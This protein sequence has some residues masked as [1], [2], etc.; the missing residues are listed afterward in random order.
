MEASFTTAYDQFYLASNRSYVSYD[1]YLKT[2]PYNF[3]WPDRPDFVEKFPYQDGLLVNYW[4][5]SYSDNNTSA[6]P[7]SGVVLPID[8]HPRAHYNL[9]GA[10]WRGRIQNYDAPFGLQK[11]DSF[12]LHVNGK[13]SYVRGQAANAVFDDSDP[14][15]Y[16][17]PFAEAGLPRVGVKVA[18]V[19]VQDRGAQAE[20]RQH[21]DPDP[22]VTVRQHHH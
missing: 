1:K 12:T 11:A 13:A 18:G 21:D 3:G 4:D 6:H 2:G 17:T 9:E 5:T 16:F 14:N 20:R 8:S 15:R 10:A 7:G 19:G 22:V